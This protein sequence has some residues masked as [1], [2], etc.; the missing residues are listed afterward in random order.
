MLCRM[1]SLRVDID[2][3]LNAID[4]SWRGSCVVL[5]EITLTR[6]E[7]FLR[8]P[9]DMRL[10]MMAELG[11]VIGS[12]QNIPATDIDL[13]FKGQ[14]YGLPRKCLI[15][16]AIVGHDRRQLAGCARG[17]HRNGIAYAK[18]ARCDGSAVASEIKV[19]SVDIL[20]GK[21]RSIVILHIVNFDR[22]QKFE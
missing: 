12:N 3:V 21:A 11:Q 20:N 22:V 14:R 10:K 8:H 18:N 15:Q 7:R 1:V 2:A 17:K 6:G 4:D 9:H 5:D 19:W 16:R 13:I